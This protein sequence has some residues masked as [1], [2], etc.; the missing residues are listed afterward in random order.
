MPP[1][2]LP[3]KKDQAAA[4]AKRKSTASRGVEALKKVN[5]TSMSKM[6]SFFKPKGKT[7]PKP[8]PA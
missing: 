5:T 8:A 4:G 1:T 7:E 6:T 3:G 2:N